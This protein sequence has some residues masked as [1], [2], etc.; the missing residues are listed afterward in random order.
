MRLNNPPS[1]KRVISLTSLIDVVFLLLVFF[2][3]SSTFLKFGTVTIETA[4]AG[5]IDKPTDPAKI[6]L[7]HIAAHGELRVNGAATQSDGLTASLDQLIEQGATQ[8]VVV[9]MP[10]A[11]VADLVSAVARV[12][13]SNFSSVR[14]VD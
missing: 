6:V 5:A 9:A 2:M 12:R 10:D 13:R 11:K 14:V 7:V 3:L 1:R 4:G 8:A